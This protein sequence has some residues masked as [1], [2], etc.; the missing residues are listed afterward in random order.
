M[1]RKFTHKQKLQYL[2][3]GYEFVH[4]GNGTYKTY[5]AGIGVSRGLYYRWIQK[6][7]DEAGIPARQYEVTSQ[8]ANRG[9]TLHTGNK[10]INPCAATACKWRSL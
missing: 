2:K 8:F 4:S 10:K 7:T 9:F 5:I 1:G 3:D 6:H